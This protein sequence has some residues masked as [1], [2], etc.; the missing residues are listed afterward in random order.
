MKVV[1]TYFLLTLCF[2]NLRSLTLQEVARHIV[3]RGLHGEP[4]EEAV[5]EMD[6]PASVKPS[7]DHCP[8]LPS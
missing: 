2:L 3:K 8:H 7:D 6:S 4:C 5:L 1:E